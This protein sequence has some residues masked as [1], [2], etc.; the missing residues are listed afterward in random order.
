[1]CRWNHFK[2]NNEQRRWF[3]FMQLRFKAEEEWLL[4]SWVSA[5]NHASRNPWRAGSLSVCYWGLKLYRFI[6]WRPLIWWNQGK[7]ARDRR[8]TKTK[9]VQCNTEEARQMLNNSLLICNNKIIWS[10][11][12]VPVFSPTGNVPPILPHCCMLKVRIK[13]K[14]IFVQSKQCSAPENEVCVCFF[15]VF[16]FVWLETLECTTKHQATWVRFHCMPM[17]N[18][19]CCQI[20]FKTSALA[21][22]R[23]NN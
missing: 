8:P 6:W 18:K 9:K 16:L 11:K 20:I 5:G 2:E 10:V 4:Y 15:S 12:Y 1:M 17:K 22:A 13:N 19:V 3:S 23:V 21:K 7:A 14:I